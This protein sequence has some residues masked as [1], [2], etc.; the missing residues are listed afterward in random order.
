MG[1]R[2][3]LLR[4]GSTLMPVGEA[5]VISYFWPLSFF[6]TLGLMLLSHLLSVAVT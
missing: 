4:V 3:C 5:L 2:G 6:F 1:K